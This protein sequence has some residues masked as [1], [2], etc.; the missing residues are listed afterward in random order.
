[1]VAATRLLVAGTTRRCLG[2]MAGLSR[3]QLTRPLGRRV[4]LRFGKGCQYH[5]EVE[6]L[7]RNCEI[8]EKKRCNLIMA[9]GNI[10]ASFWGD[11]L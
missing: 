6:N 11:S 8:F 4:S 2:R 1:V 9:R 10:A 3:G 5:G 7:S